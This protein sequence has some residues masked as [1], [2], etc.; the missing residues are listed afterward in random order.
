M[1]VTNDKLDAKVDKL[2]IKHNV[3]D[4]KVTNID[5]RLKLVGETHNLMIVAKQEYE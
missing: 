1:E 2:E 5:N 3:L 4:A